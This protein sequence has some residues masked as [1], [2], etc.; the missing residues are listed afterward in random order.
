M[1]TRIPFLHHEIL[2]SGNPLGDFPDISSYFSEYSSIHVLLD[3][4]SFRHCFPIVRLKLSLPETNVHVVD[5][6]ESSKSFLTAGKLVE[7]LYR[8]GAD[9]S[10]LLLVIGGGMLC[11]LGGFVAG[12]YMRGIAHVLMPTTLM[13]MVD[14]SVGGKCAVNV[15]GVKNLAGLF[16]SP[17]SVLIYP[18]FLKTL[19]DRELLSGFAEV[20][21]HCILSGERVPDFPNGFL[22][23]P[24]MEI[25]SL[26]ESSVRF[27]CSVVE[28]DFGDNGN[29]RQ[30]NFGHTVGHVIESVSNSD[31][32]D[33]LLHGEAVA[34]G[35]MVEAILS[36]NLTGY[37]KEK[38]INLLA[39]IRHYFGA[40]KLP[41]FT[42]SWPLLLA[43]D[44]KTLAGNF[45]MVLLDK[46]SK[47]K[48]DV[49]VSLESIRGAVDTL[50]K[51]LEETPAR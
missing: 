12:N 45:R 37:P 17:V 50:P 4:N 5:A 35:I 30:L 46:N 18:E 41:V 48:T 14:A 44:K 49:M 1:L 23:A 26:I 40:L 21:K 34:L 22:N 36:H 11:D 8:S 20:I 38:M 2:I 15:S 10:T 13:A 16:K 33:P 39:I 24:I 25:Y 47:P 43:G 7:A 6:G 51:F 28:S 29:R 31:D 19:P 42:D 9:R 32:H 27:K 3:Q